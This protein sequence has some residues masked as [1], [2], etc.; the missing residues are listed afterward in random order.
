MK[1]PIPIANK[2]GFTLIEVGLSMTILSVI[3]LV[4]VQVLDQTQRTWKRGM[5]N[6]EQFREARMAFESITQNV[7]Q[8]LLNTYLAYQY[9]NGDTP[10]IPES[11]SQAPLGYIRQSELQFITGQAAGLLG[12]GQTAA[13]SGHAMF[14]QA[15]LGLSDR[16][17]YESLSKLLCGRGYFVMHGTDEA[18]RPAHVPDVRSRFRLWEYRP[19]AEENTVYSSTAGTWFQDATSGIISAEESA[20]RPAHSRPIAENI[21][22]L[23]ISPQVTQQDANIKKAEPWWIAPGYAY[24]STD[25]ANTTMD[26]PQGTQHMLPPRVMVTLVAIDEASAR[27]LA[28]QSPDGMPQLIPEGAFTKCQDRQADMQAL[29]AALHAKQLNYRVF[30]S[31]ITMR[32]SKWGLLR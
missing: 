8:A 13:L 28:E 4:S 3:M 5:A 31:T 30:S 23:I 21:V 27:K 1:H 26:S 9:N 17:G 14:F 15:R 20:E 6:I 2:R 12:G 11:K 29:E 16:E 10:T 25:M 32:N 7:R 18:F 24:D 22:A 19:T